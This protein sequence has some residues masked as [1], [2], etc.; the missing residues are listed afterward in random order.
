MFNRPIEKD[1]YFNRDEGQYH[2]SHV[3]D[4]QLKA[5]RN[6]NNVSKKPS[7]SVPNRRSLLHNNCLERASKRPQVSAYKSRLDNK[8]STFHTNTSFY[9]LDSRRMFVE[10]N[11][12]PFKT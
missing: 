3:F 9:E 5:S 10:S 6:T 2:L 8:I 7:T 11:K 4:D 12:S 1:K